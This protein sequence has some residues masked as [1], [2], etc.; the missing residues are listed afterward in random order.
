[1]EKIVEC[2][3]NFSEGRDQKKIELIV[4]AI[5]SIPDVVL[6]DCEM[7]ADHNRSVIT[8]VG[9]PD[10]V[11]EA[12]FRAAATT[13]ELID[14]NQ[15]K[16]EHPRIG[17]LDVLPFVP[18]EGVTMDECVVLARH[19]GERIARELHI[20][21]YLYEKAAT[22][23]DRVDLHEVR[24]G[25]FEGLRK[26][27]ET[28][29]ARKPDFGEA[30]VHPTAG[31]MAVGARPP[32]IA[33]NIN[34][35]TE[36]L[37]IAKKIAKAVRGRDGGLQYVKA[38]GLELKN[39][40]QVQVSMNLV[41]YEETPIFRVFEMV[42]REAERYGV[43]IAGSEIV[44][45]VPQAALNACSDFYL[46]IKN[47][48]EDLILEHRL[49][50][51]LAKRHIEFEPA[52][53]SDRRRESERARERE[54]YQD[55]PGSTSIDT[56]AEEVAEGTLTPDGGSVAAYAGAL[57]ASLGALVC[58]LTIG[59]K[60]AVEAEIRGVLYQLGKLREDLLLAMSEE[61]ETRVHVLD[62]IALPRNTEAERLARTTAIEEASKSA[63]AVPLRV[64]QSAM[65]VLE[66]LSELS[67]IGSPSAFANLA[68]GAQLAISA[69]RGA[70]YDILSQLFSI[71]DEEFN[72]YRRAEL[73][74]LI[75]RGQERV[76]EI[77]ALF[78]RLYP[79]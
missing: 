66:L 50:T 62:A 71:N 16:G 38:L 11:V 75:T 72:R 13:I 15:H 78:F 53:R 49:Q 39:R 59:Q 76:D 17:A 25:E 68:V 67:E 35:A 27:I 21:V 36:N 23:P 54:I 40:R 69:M 34:L 18:I 19:T 61:E 77:E 55:E 8:F 43:A 30:K 56:F 60:A 33:Y 79:R 73:S 7:D 32:L 63:V 20:P 65:E 70:V 52:L 4:S 2:V 24:R 9:E 12:A 44:G 37:S 47:Y 51:E 10:A 48:S 28:D 41:N 29:P 5:A 42:K 57:A 46:R 3:P 26:E 6:L 45:L 74:D 14:L 64:A 58:N 1:M 31:A 22:R